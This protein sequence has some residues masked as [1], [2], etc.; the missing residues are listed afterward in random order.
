MG[1][2]VSGF[3]LEQWQD[4]ARAI[5]ADLIE[6]TSTLTEAQFHASPRAGGW[7]IG[8]CLEHLIL[9]GHALLADWDAAMRGTTPVASAAENKRPYPWWRRL[10]LRY[11]EN[12]HQLKLRASSPAIPYLRRSIRT[13]NEAFFETHQE[14]ARRASGVAAA[15]IHGARVRFPP[16]DWLS[17][18]LDFTFDLALA[19]ERRHIRQ[20][21]AVRRLLV[22]GG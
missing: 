9:T 21:W 7:S 13:T 11:A 1:A 17:H 10:L 2:E 18:P 12:P 6:L 4:A 20:A 3:E 14:M 5:E 16:V 22:D 15:G 19:H 8:L